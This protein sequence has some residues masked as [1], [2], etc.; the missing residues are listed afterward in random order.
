MAVLDTHKENTCQLIN[1]QACK[2]AHAR[3]VKLGREIYVNT[4]LDPRENLWE[5]RW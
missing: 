4:Q 5:E 1:M 3:T 2:V